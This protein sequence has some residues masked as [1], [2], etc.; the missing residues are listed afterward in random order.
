MNPALSTDPIYVHRYVIRSGTS[1]N[2]ASMRREFHG[3]LIRVG[4]GFGC[5]HPWPEFGDAPIDEHLDLLSRGIATPLAEIALRCARLDGEARC[6]GISLFA[7]LEIPRSHYSWNFAQETG[8][9]LE[10][11]LGESWPAIKAKGFANWGET[12]RFLES[13]AKVG[14]SAHL[15]LRIDFNGCLDQHGFEK[16]CEFLPLRVYRHLDLVEDP[17]PYDAELWEHFRS[18]W[19]VR[20]ALDKGW[21]SA[22]DG[23]DALVVKPSRRDWRMVAAAFPDKPLILTSAMDHALGQAFAAFE[24]AIA[25]RELPGRISFCGLATQHLFAP[26][27]FFDRLTASGGYLSVDREGTGLGF[28]DI[29]EKLPWKRLT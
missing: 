17:L 15:A 13:V 29:L 4:D 9:Q 26:D 1:L 25:L 16:F 18:R 10:R 5:I 19:G 14:E 23:F 7:G 2:A 6:C 24:A 3:A 11:V 28:D 21:R 27:A 12:L 8:P 20:L 22:T